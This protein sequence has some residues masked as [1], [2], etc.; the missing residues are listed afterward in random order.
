MFGARR[1]QIANTSATGHERGQLVVGEQ[2]GGD[3]GAAITAGEH[4]ARSGLSGRTP[5]T[6]AHVGE[7]LGHADLQRTQLRGGRPLVES[8]ARSLL[9]PEPAVQLDELV[10]ARPTVPRAKEQPLEGNDHARAA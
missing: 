1:E 3:A 2:L 4:P 9:R 5:A 6:R 8:R 7:D 10:R